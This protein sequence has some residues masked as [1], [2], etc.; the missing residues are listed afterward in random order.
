MAIG[1]IILLVC[2]GAFAGFAGSML[3]LGGAF[4]MT[5]MQLIVYTSMGLPADLAVKLAFGTNLLVIFPTAI[6]GAIGHHRRGAVMWRPAIIMGTCSLITSFAGSTAAAHLP[7]QTLRIIFGVLVFASMIRMLTSKRIDSDC[8]PTTD[9]RVLIAWAIPLGFAT[10]LLGIGGGILAIPIMTIFL[11]FKLRTATATS[12]AMIILSST[13]GIVGYVV[14]G[15]NVHG[16]PPYTIGYIDLRSWL[17]LTVPSIVM[18]QVGARVAH[19]IPSRV[20]LYM[21]I[22]VMSYSSLKMLGL[23][24]VLHWPL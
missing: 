17:L 4:I 21:L 3:G 5:P 12:L 7:G 19:K 8:K 15:L 9:P 18:A 20:L 11:H 6:S 16:L 22:A 23:F 24:D 1:N 2:T 13:G 14:N 10:G